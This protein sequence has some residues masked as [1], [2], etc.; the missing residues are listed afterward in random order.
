MTIR[1]QKYRKEKETVLQA[2]SDIYVLSA[3]AGDS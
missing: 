1:G 2:Y 3:G